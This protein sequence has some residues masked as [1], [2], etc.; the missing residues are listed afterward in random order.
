MLKDIPR[1][2]VRIITYNQEKFIGRALDSIISQKDYVFEVIIL[3]DCSTDNN[4]K[5]IQQYA[6]KYPDLIKP[7]RNEKNIGIMKNVEKRLKLPLK[8]DICYNLSGDD[9]VG[10]GWF[11][12]V[13]E[14]ISENNIDYKNE[15][16][17]I[18][19]DSR[20]I[21][22]NNDSYVFKNKAI[23]SKLNP[24]KLYERGMINNRA[25]CYN[26]NILKKFVNVSQGRSLI[27]ENAQDAQL[28]IFS[29]KTY[30]LPFVGN[31]YH[32]NIGVSSNSNDKTFDEYNN[33]MKY[34]FSFFMQIGIKMDKYDR[35]LPK[36][37]AATKV[38]M[39]Q[40]SF[41]S[42]LN[43]LKFYI[44]SYDP[45]IGLRDIKF[46]KF[47]FSLLRRIPHKKPLQW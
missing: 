2:S 20:C 27:A 37:N 19:G 3:D 17:C 16:F 14:F 13:V 38:M 26:K 7:I 33:T 44:K 1:I 34:A 4:W 40:K 8:G 47:I 35:E 28:H 11:K 12:K 6:L 36:F 23:L 43:F 41:K 31:I 24:L 9:E 32:T 5:V 10:P 21:Y 46:R 15:L 30:Y 29:E 18:Y 25:T 45:K 39:K 42:F 22:P